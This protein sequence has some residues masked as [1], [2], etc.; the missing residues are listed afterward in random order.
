MSTVTAAADKPPTP[1][2]KRPS[3]SPG[4]IRSDELY[5]LLEFERRTSIGEWGRR[6]LRRGGMPIISVAGKSFIR[7]ADFLAAAERQLDRDR[8]RREVSA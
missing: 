5:T 7:G 1:K 6:Q 8:Q 2:L 4:V 3:E